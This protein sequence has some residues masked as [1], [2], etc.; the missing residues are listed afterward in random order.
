M[1]HYEETVW[2][3]SRED[4]GEEGRD[5]RMVSRFEDSLQ[6]VRRLSMASLRE[7]SIRVIRVTS[8]R[9]NH[10]GSS[11]EPA[12]LSTSLLLHLESHRQG[13]TDTHTFSPYQ[14]PYSL[15]F[16]LLFGYH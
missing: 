9:F 15:A 8:I 6:A 11:G 3:G 5:W 4:V 12:V 7:G 2:L 13:S 16:Q 1:G 14:G 10:L